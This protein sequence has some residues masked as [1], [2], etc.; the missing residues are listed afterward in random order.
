MSNVAVLRRTDPSESS[1]EHLGRVATEHHPTCRGPRHR[2][3]GG[4][5][6][7]TARLPEGPSQ[8]VG[9]GARPPA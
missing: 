4:A 9:V 8:A 5:Q 2:S 3:T 7:L 1:P 6:E